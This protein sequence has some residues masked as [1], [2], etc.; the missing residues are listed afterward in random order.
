MLERT[1]MDRLDE[2]QLGHSTSDLAL[3]LLHGCW[4]GPCPTH[5]WLKQVTVRPSH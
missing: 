3:T 2:N 5:F 1:D 4:R